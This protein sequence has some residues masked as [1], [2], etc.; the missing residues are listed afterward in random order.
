MMYDDELR[1]YIISCIRDYSELESS[2]RDRRKVDNVL[3]RRAAIKHV[4]VD[5][6]SLLAVKRSKPI[7]AIIDD[8]IIDLMAGFDAISNREITKTVYELWWYSI[9]AAKELKL[10]YF[11]TN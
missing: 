10:L 6:C 8:Y 9:E 2:E 1:N 5:L 4:R 7:T 3:I 11:P